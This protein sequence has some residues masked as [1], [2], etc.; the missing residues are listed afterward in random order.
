M[1]TQLLQKIEQEHLKNVPNFGVGDRVAVHFKIVEGTT[2]RIQVY[3]G[4]VIQKKGTG[5]QA[6]FT[7]R[8]ISSGVGVERVFPVHSPRIDKIEIVKKAKVRR[9]KLYYMRG[10]I[11]KAAMKVKED[12]SKK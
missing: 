4:V 8:K 6:S 1:S 2:E 12:F 5:V 10:R 7:V 3:E 9:A 11:G